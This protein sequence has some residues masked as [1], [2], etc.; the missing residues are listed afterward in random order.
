MTTQTEA[1]PVIDWHSFKDTL[2]TAPPKEITLTISGDQ[3]REQ[4]GPVYIDGRGVEDMAYLQVL[5]DPATNT[6]TITV[7]TGDQSVTFAGHIHIT[8]DQVISAEPIENITLRQH[9]RTWFH[10]YRTQLDALARAAVWDDLMRSIPSHMRGTPRE[11][12]G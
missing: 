3:R 8:V 7:E 1:L 4:D 10:R 9:I 11:K 6:Y 12:N 5:A 2:G